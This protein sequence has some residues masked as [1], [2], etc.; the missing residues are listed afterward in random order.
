MKD[1]AID[2][3]CCYLSYYYYVGCFYIDVRYCRM[4]VYEG[5]CYWC[6]S[7]INSIIIF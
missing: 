2:V 7:I 4:L 5:S 6:V 1:A 3:V